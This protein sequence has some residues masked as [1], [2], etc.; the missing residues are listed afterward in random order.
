VQIED[1][2]D[3]EL[4]EAYIKSLAKVDRVIMEFGLPTE[5]PDRSAT[6]VVG[7]SLV[8]V[9]L[10]GLIDLEKEI[11]RQ[12]LKLENLT[13]ER[14]GLSDRINNPRFLENAPKEVIIQTRER[15]GEIDQQFES[16]KILLKSLGN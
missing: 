12:T 10:E 13:K 6:A 8:V 1:R 7:K 5:V 3:F 14:K 2:E 16:I 11:K 9:S 4:S 15:I